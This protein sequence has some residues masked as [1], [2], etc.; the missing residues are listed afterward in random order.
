MAE[1]FKIMELKRVSNE[2]EVKV[3]VPPNWMGFSNFTMKIEAE[4]TPVGGGLVERDLADVVKSIK[5]RIAYACQTLA[6]TAFADLDEESVN[7][8]KGAILHDATHS[9]DHA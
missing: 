8:V 3:S 2:W 6:N 5:R 9:P 7:S 1:T 4:M